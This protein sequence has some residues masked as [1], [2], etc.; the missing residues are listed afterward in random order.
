M[1]KLAPIP[2]DRFDSRLK[3]V[4]PLCWAAHFSKPWEAARRDARRSAL[5]M[6]DMLA[7][8]SKT[9]LPFSWL[10]NN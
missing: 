8:I 10:D 3:D 1:P 7:L 9:P 4:L 2:K 5:R 6:I